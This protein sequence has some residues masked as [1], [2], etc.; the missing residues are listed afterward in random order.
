MDCGALAKRVVRN[1]RSEVKS[2]IGHNGDL[3]EAY[4]GCLEQGMSPEE[5]HDHLALLL[6][7]VR[8]AS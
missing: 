1:L 4:Q 5:A 6:A 7:V 3:T 8:Y 2:R